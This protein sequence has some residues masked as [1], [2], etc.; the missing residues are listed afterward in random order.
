MNHHDDRRSLSLRP[1]ERWYVV[2]TQPRREV[3]AH[4][5]LARQGFRPFLPRLRRTVRHA[6]RLRTVLVPLFP[7]YLFLPLDLERV[8]WRS[9]NAT[10]GVISL[11]MFGKRPSVVPEGVV[12]EIAQLSGADG[13]IDPAPIL[14]PGKRVRLTRDPFGD[15]VAELLELDDRGRAR[16]LLE[17]LGGT[18]VLLVDRHQLM[19]VD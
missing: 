15:V 13:V 9:V 7:D 14:R 6:R 12:E 10:R 16:I 2:R 18:R 3:L 5:Q 8:R 19:P 11:V 1:G 17:I 4:D